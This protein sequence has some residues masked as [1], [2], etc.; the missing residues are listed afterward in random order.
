MNNKQIKTYK[1]I[2]KTPTPANLSWNDIESMLLALGAEISE[3]EGSRVRI[4]LNGERAVFH[5]PH[6][7][8]NTDKGA[9]K[10]IRR[11]LE[12]ARVHYD[13]I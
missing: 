5:R 2:Y 3:G 10:S 12:N 13:D 7:D 8:T 9:V 11:F 1:E 6:P 4:K